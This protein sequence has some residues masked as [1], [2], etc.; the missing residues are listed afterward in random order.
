[1]W[2][3]TEQEE[4]SSSSCAVNSH[5]CFFFCLHCL[6]VCSA[7]A[8]TLVVCLSPFISFISSRHSLTDLAITL[9]PSRSLPRTHL[10]RSHVS[11]SPLGSRKCCHGMPGMVSSKPA[12]LPPGLWLRGVRALLPSPSPM[13]ARPPLTRCRWV[14]Q[15][16]L[17]PL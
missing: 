4:H 13:G 5:F 10:S 3:N 14:L 7:L 6:L 1:M 17:L 16:P 15:R 12:F 11:A 2:R 8:Q 9:I